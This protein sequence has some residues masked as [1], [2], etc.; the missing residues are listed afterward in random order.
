MKGIWLIV[1]KIF[2]VQSNY[3]TRLA[4]YTLG[5]LLVTLVVKLLVPGSALQYTNLIF[6]LF[7]CVVLMVS[8]FTVI[9]FSKSDASQ[10]AKGFLVVSG[11]RFF[12][13]LL[14]I[15]AISFLMHHEA[16]WFIISFFVYYLF[17]TVFEILSLMDGFKSKK[18]H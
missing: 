13:Y 8:R 4:F 10:F 16:I 11:I 17:F 6:P 15:S 14:I 5:V 18:I 12:L 1:S 7:F 9:K 3:F 2:M